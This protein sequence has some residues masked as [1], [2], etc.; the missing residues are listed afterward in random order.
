MSGEARLLA[1]PAGK[2]LRLVQVLDRLH[3]T[4]PGGVVIG[5]MAVLGRVATSFRVTDDVDHV[6]EPDSGLA[7]V[8]EAG[9]SRQGASSWVIDDVKVDVIEVGAVP[10]AAV[11][12]GAW[13]DEL[14]ARL[15]AVAHQWAF[16]TAEPLTIEVW[17][18]EGPMVASAT[19]LAATTPALCAMKLQSA[20]RRPSARRYKAGSDYADLFRLLGGDGGAEAVAALGAAPAGLGRWAV[21][22]LRHR[23]GDEAE[24]TVRTIRAATN[25]PPDEVITPSDLRALLDQVS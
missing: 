19:M 7:V 14:D 23:F 2:L 22:E 21:G 3:G 17:A 20:R 24:R 10:A 9:G 15:F 4:G 13:P 25:L 11:P 18:D 5:G 16:D 1:D 8:L 12:E 6:A